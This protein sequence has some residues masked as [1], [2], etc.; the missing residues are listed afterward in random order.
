MPLGLLQDQVQVAAACLAAYQISNE[1]RYLAVA[2][3]LA[4]SVGR[5]YADSLGGY[6]DTVEPPPGLGDRTKHVFD[7]MLPGP[8]AEA[9]RVLARLADVTGDVSYRRR[10]QATLEA[11]AGTVAGGAGL[12]ATTF[13]AAA[14]E[15]LGTP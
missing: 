4:A 1:P 8:N 14:R 6:F 2:I 15:T 12:R 11:F 3:D 5:S 7:D 13:L 10:A 9:A